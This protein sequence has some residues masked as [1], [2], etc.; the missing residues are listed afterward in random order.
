MPFGYST[1]ERRD[2][3]IFAFSLL[4]E[5]Y[6]Q[7]DWTVFTTANVILQGN[8]T[9]TFSVYYG[10]AYGGLAER[11]QNIRRLTSVDSV[12]DVGNV[13]LNYSLE[14]FTEIFFAVHTE[15]NVSVHSVVNIVFV[16]TKPLRDFE[17][18]ALNNHLKKIY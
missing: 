3:L 2:E 5:L 15:S 8:A 6:G 12:G 17:T 9:G 13:E 7:N 16:I 14:D 11:Q 4:F 1:A 10:Q 18:Q